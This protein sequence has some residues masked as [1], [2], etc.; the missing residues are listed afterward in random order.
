MERKREG[1][2]CFLMEQLIIEFLSHLL[3]STPVLKIPTLTSVPSIPTLASLASI[4]SSPPF[5]S[6]F[7]TLQWQIS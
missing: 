1:V 2:M 6:F 4:H 7:G 5:P 3:P